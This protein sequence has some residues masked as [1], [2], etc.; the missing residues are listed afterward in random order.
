M[1]WMELIQ[2]DRSD[3]RGNSVTVREEAGLRCM[4]TQRKSLGTVIDIKAHSLF[5]QIPLTFFYT[6]LLSYK[7]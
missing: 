1:A 3:E 5:L 6:K 2:E 7:R 4:M